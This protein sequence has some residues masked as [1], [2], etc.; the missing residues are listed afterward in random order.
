MTTKNNL[1]RQVMEALTAKF[2][3]TNEQMSK[4]EGSLVSN[5]F[6]TSD[7]RVKVAVMSTVTRAGD[8][9]DFAV[10]IAVEEENRKGMYFALGD[11]L[12]LPLDKFPEFKFHHELRAKL[13]T[14]F[15][16]TD[17]AIPDTMSK[18]VVSFAKELCKVL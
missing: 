16:S 17:F 11:R 12:H 8:V 15:A 2:G 6:N 13:S 1:F 18:D 9:K 7:E 14:S 5:F 3:N 4:K 10:T